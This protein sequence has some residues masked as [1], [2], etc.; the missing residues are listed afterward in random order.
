VAAAL[1]PPLSGQQQ[2]RRQR[3]RQL[4][5][6]RQCVCGS[7]GADRLSGIRRS[8]NEISQLA[9]LPRTTQLPR[10]FPAWQIHG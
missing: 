7:L 8:R 1:Q 9:R 2:R 5:R 6:R 3:R 10:S 4:T